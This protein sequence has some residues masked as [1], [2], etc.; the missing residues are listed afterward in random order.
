MSKQRQVARQGVARRVAENIRPAEQ[1][2]DSAFEEL[3]RFASTIPRARVEAS[4]STTVGH[5][6]YERVAESLTAIVDA[7]GRLVEA[8]EELARVGERLGVTVSHGPLDKSEP[9]ARPTVVGLA[10]VA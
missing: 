3:A 8:H 7:R 2:I 9:V 6:V 4:L 10:R 1:A 5:P